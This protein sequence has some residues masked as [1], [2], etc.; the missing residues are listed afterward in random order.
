M[1]KPATGKYGELL[2]GHVGHRSERADQ[3]ECAMGMIG[4]KVRCYCRAQRLANQNDSVGI[5]ALVVRKPSI[6]G[7][8][9]RIATRLTWFAFA[10]A[11]ARI[12][13]GENCLAA[14]VVPGSQGLAAI[15]DVTPIPVAIERGPLVL[16]PA[17]GRRP[18]C[19]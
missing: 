11:E 14:F 15:A 13:E 19:M 2:G 17:L 10:L 6:R 8:G 9:S 4:G 3:H 1:D 12:I 7:S 16:V 5:N 18:P